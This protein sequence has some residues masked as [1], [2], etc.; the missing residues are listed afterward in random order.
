[1]TM[2]DVIAA[3]RYLTKLGYG[4]DSG[5]GRPDPIGRMRPVYRIL[6]VGLLADT[7]VEQGFTHEEA[8]TLAKARVN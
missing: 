5:K 6:A 7:Y 8:M 4:E 1:M 2:D 3:R